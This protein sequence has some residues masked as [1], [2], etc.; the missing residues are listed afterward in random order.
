[1]KTC[2]LPLISLMLLPALCLAS[3]FSV[4]NALDSGPGS[5]REAILDANANPGPDLITFAIGSGVK[6][7]VPASPLPTVTD[8]VTIDGTTQPG[9]ASSPIIELNGVAGVRDGLSILAGNSTVRGMVIN[10]FSGSG[11]VLQEGGSNWITGNFIGTDVTG[12]LNYGNSDCGLALYASCANHIGGT[13]VVDRNLISGNVN[14]GVLL[15]VGA[16]SNLIEGNIIGLNVAGTLRLGNSGHGIHCASSTDNIIGGSVP[17]ARNV[18]SGNG[19]AGVR[20][21]DHADRNGVL[22]NYLGTDA[23][24]TFDRGNSGNAVT[25]YNSYSNTVGQPLLGAGNLL[26]GNGDRGIWIA[27]GASANIIQGNFIGTDFT[28][29]KALGNSDQG[30]LIENRTCT[31]NL[32]GGAVPGARNVVSA[33][34]GSG[35]TLQGDDNRVQGNCIGT[36]ITGLVP[37]GNKICGVK[38]QSGGSGN[39]IGGTSS[40][41]ANRIAFNAEDGIRVVTGKHN[42]FTANLIFSNNG[43][44]ID[45]EGDGATPNDPLDTDSGPNNL[46]NN[47]V[48]TAVAKTSVGIQ[49]RGTINTVPSTTGIVIEFFS[50]DRDDSPSY[51]EGQTFL[52]RI[53]VATDSAGNAAFNQTLPVTVAA[54][55]YITA[56]ATLG[57][58]TSEF[59]AGA[60][61]LAEPFLTLRRLDG[62]RAALEWPAS[63]TGYQLEAT[64]GLAG[65]TWT[66]N[67]SL[68]S[69]YVTN[70]LNT[71]VIQMTGNAR[72]L[73]LRKP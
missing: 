51:G 46:Q 10:R 68:L 41:E 30:I 71:V 7:I 43:L 2:A 8:P 36:D 39:L 22:G 58:N 67:I 48:L 31:N 62:Q 15:S 56:T 20:L 3:S 19:G 4:T 69:A 26:S 12:T 1:M 49:I 9:F 28:G 61:V 44:G 57:N 70:D 55:S 45:L 17:G 59:S 50:N 42:S 29:T 34:G 21:D 33:N 53:T 23:T 24:G 32:I 60:T 5:L 11:I 65:A 72:F 47:P 54:S 63:V 73:R 25:I 6:T 16:C 35:V 66:T 40:G 38:I 13:N 52:G 64:T 14:D 27:Q 37:L 18:S